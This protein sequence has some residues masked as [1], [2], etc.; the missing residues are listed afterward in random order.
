MV[1]CEKAARATASKLAGLSR[2]PRFLSSF[3]APEKAVTACSS[4]SNLGGATFSQP[5]ICGPSGQNNYCNNAMTEVL[6]TAARNDHRAINEGHKFIRAA[7]REA[8][9]NWAPIVLNAPRPRLVFRAKTVC[10]LAATRAAKI[11]PA[12][13]QSLSPAS[14][15]ASTSKPTSPICSHLPGEWL[16]SRPVRELLPWLWAPPDP[17]EQAKS[18]GVKVATYAEAMDGRYAPRLSSA[19]AIG[20]L[21]R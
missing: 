1:L 8:A 18:G 6:I 12:L 11:G 10:S 16:A 7:L 20:L 21:P 2:R 14:S 19:S 4:E 9:S 15:T 17:T 13:H 5:L 3:R